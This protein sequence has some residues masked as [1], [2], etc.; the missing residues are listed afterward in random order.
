MKPLTAEWV[1]KAEGD[2]A[3]VEREARARR[4]PSWDGLG[5][6]AQQCI[7]KYLKARL[8]EAGRPSERTHD[9]TRLLDGVVDIEP[10]W[11][12]YRRDLAYMTDFAVRYRYPG[13]S[14]TREAALRARHMCRSFRKAARFALGLD[15]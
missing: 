7:E 2:F 4:A 1:A 3:M 13:E 8:Q 6:H 9:L 12:P 11:E 5:F 15:V 14:V 10:L